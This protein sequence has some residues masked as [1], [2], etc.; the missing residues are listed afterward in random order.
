MNLRN[1]KNNVIGY[2]AGGD[3]L[4]FK[5]EEHTFREFLDDEECEICL[6]EYNTMR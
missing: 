5:R 3:Y 6:D 4:R 1:I 2:F